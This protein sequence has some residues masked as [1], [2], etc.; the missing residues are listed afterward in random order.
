MRNIKIALGH[1]REAWEAQQKATAVLSS[2][3]ASYYFERVE[4][5]VDALFGKYA[6]FHEG[7]RVA[8]T[9]APETA[10]T[11]WKGLEHIL[12]IGALATVDNVDYYGGSFVADIVLDKETWIGQEGV[13]HPIENKHTFRFQE[14]SLA[15]VEVPAR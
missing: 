5:Y 2:G 15:K 3:P 10:G 6:P 4:E 7:D 1:Y 13:E 11:A 8:I 14:Q 9:K 12:C